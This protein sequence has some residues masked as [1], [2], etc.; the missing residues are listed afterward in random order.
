[1]PTWIV[2]LGSVREGRAGSASEVSLERSCGRRMLPPARS[3]PA[4]DQHQTRRPPVSSM[5]IAVVGPV[6]V[7]AS[8]A[9]SL[10]GAPRGEAGSQTAAAACQSEVTVV[11][12]MPRASSAS[13][14]SLAGTSLI[15][16]TASRRGL[17]WGLTPGDLAGFSAGASGS[18]RRATAAA[19]GLGAYS[20]RGVTPPVP[21]GIAF[22]SATAET[23]AGSAEGLVRKAPMP[24]SVSRQRT[25]SRE[26]RARIW[27]ASHS[28]AASVSWVT[29]ASGA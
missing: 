5:T 25:S 23:I 18:P 17:G 14:R 26:P 4:E 1:M 7:A 9:S 24:P 3:V 10:G 20:P 27:V 29:G 21:V 16:S 12:V 28:A 22:C 11:T 8:V 15:A 13:S 6:L 19:S 2:G